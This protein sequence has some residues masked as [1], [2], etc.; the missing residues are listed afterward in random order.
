MQGE[1]LM[2]RQGKSQF[3]QLQML[4][5]KSSKLR[6]IATGVSACRFGSVLTSLEMDRL[7]VCSWS[8]VNV[9]GERT[10]SGH[11]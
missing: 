6:T 10:Q 2:G 8:G 4:A 5:K 9:Q 1:E 7:L 11:R 3:R